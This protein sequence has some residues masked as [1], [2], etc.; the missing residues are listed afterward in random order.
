L[1][2]VLVRHQ[3]QH[4]IIVTIGVNEPEMAAHASMADPAM[5]AYRLIRRRPGAVIATIIIAR[6]AVDPWLPRP[7]SDRRAR[8]QTRGVTG[9][10]GHLRDET[11]LDRKGR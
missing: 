4:L 1:Q 9:A 8:S 10:G 6:P 3:P 2:R 7:W 5:P 11:K